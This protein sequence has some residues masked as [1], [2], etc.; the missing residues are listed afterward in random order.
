M[1]FIKSSEWNDWKQDKVT[2]AFYGATFERIEDAKDILSVSA[3]LDLDENNFYRG[4]IAAYREMVEFKVD[5][6]IDD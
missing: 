4:F 1:S 5:D 3:G 6:L 2:K